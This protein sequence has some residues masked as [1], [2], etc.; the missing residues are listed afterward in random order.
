MKTS[1]GK[2]LLW[3]ALSV[4]P[5]S[6]AAQTPTPGPNMILVQATA[7]TTDEVIKAVQTYAEGKKWAY[8]GADAV[9]PVTLMKICIPEVGR[10]LWPLGLQ[11]GALLPCGNLSVYEKDGRTEIAMLHPAYMQI[12][13]P[14]AEIKKAVDVATPLLI[15]MLKAV[16]K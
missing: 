5:L 9:G 7:K 2:L 11:I 3:A 4:L 12:L 8:L 6:V 13:Y 1:V 10:T 14:N 16:A 15:D